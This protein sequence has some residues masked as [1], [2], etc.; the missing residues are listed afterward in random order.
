MHLTAITD[1][2]GWLPRRQHP[3]F[4]TKFSKRLAFSLRFYIIASKINLPYQA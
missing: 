3:C 1:A 4:V 2:W